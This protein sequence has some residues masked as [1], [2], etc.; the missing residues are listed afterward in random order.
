[1]A[2]CDNCDPI[3]A[4]VVAAYDATILVATACMCI[5]CHNHGTKAGWNS[6]PQVI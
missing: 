1:M 3:G 2:K 6:V 5:A 4:H